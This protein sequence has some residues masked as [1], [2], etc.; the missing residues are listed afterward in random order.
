MIAYTRYQFD[1]RV[2]LEAESLV[3]W[4]Y[5]V[6]FLVPRSGQ[7]ATTFA[8]QGVT[9][10]ELN[11]GEYGGKNK[12]VYIVSYL[13]FLGFAFVACTRFYFQSGIDVVH[14][15]NMPNILVFAALIP[16]LFGCKLILD[17]H[18]NMP[19][20]YVA[21]F[22]TTS[23]LVLSLCRLEERVCCSLA[24]K[25]IA[26]N[27]VQRETLINRGIPA[28]KIAT[29]ITMPQFLPCKHSS[30]NHKQA[31]GF[32]MVN[33]GT[34]SQRLGNDLLI[35]AAA[36]LVHEIPGFELH[37]I[38]AG[39]SLDSVV[40]LSE[41][42][43]LTDHVHFHP[44]VPWDKLPE[45]LAMMDVG[46]VANR[47]NIA[48]ELMLPLK[49]IDYVVLGIPAIAP[50]LK[51]IEYYFSPDLV[52]FFEPEN[53]DSMVAATVGLYR[54]KQRRERQPQI[55]KSFLNKYG[56]DNPKHGLRELYDDLCL[57]HGS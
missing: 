4:G 6:L 36:K 1:G 38:G 49:L 47:V 43:G 14:I 35:R 34:I 40:R 20:T 51:T 42:L 37:I 41:S 26:T 12:L 11:V 18:D 45:T 21:K 15:H 48:T 30:N 22:G 54:D 56:W 52:T 39:D 28:S 17:V 19:E 16:R 10:K 50:R 7:T 57:N 53:V 27:H 29:V 2:R 3:G 25:I 13:M 8:L 31:Q 55:A 44:T 5:Q 9:V 46:I 24:H 33:H 32:R 23:R